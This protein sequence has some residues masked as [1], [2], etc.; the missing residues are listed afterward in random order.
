[1]L[2]KKVTITLFQK[3][4]VIRKAKRVGKFK[5]IQNGTFKNRKR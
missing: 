1:M 4:G 3:M 5:K 2:N